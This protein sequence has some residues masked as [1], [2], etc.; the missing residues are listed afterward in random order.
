MSS[1]VIVLP[2]AAPAKSPKKKAGRKKAGPAVS[3]LIVAAVSSSSDRGGL[4]LAALKKALKASGYDAVKNNA[5]ILVAIRRL[6][7]NK[8]LVQ[9]KGT[10]A[11]GS[12]KLNKKAP[13]ARKKKVLKKKKPKAKKAKKAKKASAKKAAGSAGPATKKSPKKKKKAKSPKK[14][15][16]PAAAK[17]PKSLKSPKK[18]K[19][20][21]TKSTKK[22]AAAKK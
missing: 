5:R 7:K 6:L 13:K 18:T 10:G 12:F 11:S 2:M 19:R 14:A 4:S 22:R 16:K 1:D 15:K 20:R 21:V 8:T 17:K 9:A 3:K